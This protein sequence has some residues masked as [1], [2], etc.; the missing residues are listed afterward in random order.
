MYV[1]LMPRGK[2]KGFS[3]TW[4]VILAES[5]CRDGPCKLCS[6]PS[7]FHA[8]AIPLQWKVCFN[9]SSSLVF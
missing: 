9:D 1:V 5:H 8:L 2:A 4:L 7:V 3:L 6:F